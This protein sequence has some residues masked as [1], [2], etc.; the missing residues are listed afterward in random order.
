MDLE[1]GSNAVCVVADVEWREHSEM[2]RGRKE[3][4]RKKHIREMLTLI[5]KNSAKETGKRK[6]ARKSNLA[7]K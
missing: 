4:K 1:D 6:E 5:E 2:T 7:T 3:E